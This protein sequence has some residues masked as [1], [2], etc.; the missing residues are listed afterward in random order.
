MKCWQTLNQFNDFCEKIRI[1][2]Q[3][4][5]EDPLLDE[6]YEMSDE[7]KIVETIDE[8]IVFGENIDEELSPSKTTTLFIEKDSFDG[9]DSLARRSKLQ[10]LC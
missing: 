6:K 7:E 9:C 8:E 2:H 1:V 5:M 4:M 3:N 10:L